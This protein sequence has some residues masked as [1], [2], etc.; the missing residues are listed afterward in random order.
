MSRN[1]LKWPKL[2]CT[3]LP[4][5]CALILCVLHIGTSEHKV[6]CTWYTLS[7]LIKTVFLKHTY[8]YFKKAI[9]EVE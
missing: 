9:A 2:N 5:E 7:K 3:E 4:S 1:T 8:I 6:H